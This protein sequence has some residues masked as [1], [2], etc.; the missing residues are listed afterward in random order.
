MPSPIGHT[1]AGVVTAWAM[2]LLP[3]DR[4]WRT[5]PRSAGFL[6]RAGD[7]LT[8]VCAA[9]AASA[10][11]DLFLPKGAHRAF[12]HSVG[13]VVLV[14]SIAALVTGWVTPRRSARVALMCG[15]AYATHILLDWLA[16]DDTFPYGIRALWPLSA[17][18]YISNWNVFAGTAR[19]GVWSRPAMLQNLRAAMQET[20][21]LV[22][23]AWLVWSVRVKA[24]AR[25]AAEVS[26]RDHP[27][28]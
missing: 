1:L 23:L 27:S 12:T 5:A 9:L 11:L 15:A 28:Q 21:T 19:I 6:A 24:L 10:D 8:L 13:A 20:A 2:D 4:A 26:S 22:P 25:L 18:W 14:S 7:G 16:F 3:G 17:G